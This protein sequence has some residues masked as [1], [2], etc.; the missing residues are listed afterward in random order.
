[1]TSLTRL[2]FSVLPVAAISCAVAS[3]APKQT[4]T[5]NGKVAST[6]VR[7][8]DGKAFVP[9]GDVAR[10]LGQSVVKT[11][12][13]Y[14]ITVAGGGNEVADK[15]VGKLGDDVFTGQFKFKALNVRTANSYVTKYVEYKKT[16]TA[17]EGQILVIVDCRIKNGTPQKQELVFSTDESYGGP[18]TAITDDQEHSYRPINFEG[19]SF[20]GFDVHADEYAP[21][22]TNILP[23][24]ALDFTL[25]FSVPNDF[26]PKDLIYSLVKYSERDKAKE[27]TVDVRIH[28]N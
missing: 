8:I 14:T 21:V 28:L 24:A 7:T 6:D 22:G 15:Y 3:A 11:P 13:G 1:M 4:L 26:K 25:V 20:N 2:A 23:G 10:G 18:N 27:K 12:G 16:I 9:V 17:N 19:N 5:I